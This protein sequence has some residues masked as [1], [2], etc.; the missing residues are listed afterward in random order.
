MGFN[1]LYFASFQGSNQ[2]PIDSSNWTSAGDALQVYNAQC[3]VLS[4]NDVGFEYMNGTIDFGADQYCQYTVSAQTLSGDESNIITR[5]RYTRGSN[6]GYQFS[7]SSDSSGEMYWLVENPNNS[8]IGQGFPAPA[9]TVGD[10]LFMSVIGSSI[11]FKRNGNTLLS[12]TDTTSDP[13]GVPSLFVEPGSVYTDT[14]IINF[15]AGSYTATSTISGNTG[16]GSAVVAYSGTASGTVTANSSG[17]YSIPGLSNG[18]YQLTPSLSGYVFTPLTISV[19]FTG[20]T[21]QNFTA[22]ASAWSQIDSRTAVHGFGPAANGSVDINLTETYT[23]Q[24]SSNHKIP[25]TDS[26]RAGAPKDCRK[27]PNIPLNSRTSQK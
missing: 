13:D 22:A 23:V 17:A 5:L 9:L 8:T 3:C 20:N 26:R 7:V 27:S 12:I 15:S 19:P 1:Q 16:V 25:P 14:G 4:G 2:N 24:T 6:N 18:T 11:T 10:V 21:T